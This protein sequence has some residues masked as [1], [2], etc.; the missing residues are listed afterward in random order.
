MKLIAAAPAR[1]HH[2]VLGPDRPL[3]GAGSPLAAR[4]V[5][6]N[7]RQDSRSSLAQL[8]CAPLNPPTRTRLAG[9]RIGLIGPVLALGELGSLRSSAAR[10]PRLQVAPLDDWIRGRPCE[11]WKRRSQ[12]AHSFLGSPHLIARRLL[13]HSPPRTSLWAAAANFAPRLQL[14][15]LSEPTQRRPPPG[16]ARLIR[17]GAIGTRT[18]SCAPAR[19]GSCVRSA[20]RAQ[21][22]VSPA[23]R[24]SAPPGA[25]RFGARRAAHSKSRLERRASPNGGAALL[26]GP[27]GFSQKQNPFTPARLGVVLAQFGP[28]KTLSCY[29]HPAAASRRPAEWRWPGG[30]RV[31]RAGA[32]LRASAG[33]WRQFIFLR[34]RWARP[35]RLPGAPV[36]AIRQLRPPIRPIGGPSR[37]VGAARLH[38]RKQTND[39]ARA[40]RLASPRFAWPV[41]FCWP[42]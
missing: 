19:A 13:A 17:G 26:I 5:A 3:A 25:G 18:C 8:P 35:A 1:W 9:E 15:A 7:S 29:C 16:R 31:P 34:R 39:N 10:S 24:A 20:Q 12:F 33:Q 22:T 37:L 38:N 2:C 42:L 21:R 36:G 23:S 27:N 14:H 11:T 30:S 40:T 41:N 4:V 28:I 32:H 6:W